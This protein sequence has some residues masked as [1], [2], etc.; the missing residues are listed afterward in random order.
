MSVPFSFLTARVPPQG[1]S[2]KEGAVRVRHRRAFLL[3]RETQQSAMDVSHHGKRNVLVVTELQLNL[4]M[5]G[6][7][8]EFTVTQSL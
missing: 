8:T 5:I 4:S 2:G 6:P 1:R 7:Q 3:V